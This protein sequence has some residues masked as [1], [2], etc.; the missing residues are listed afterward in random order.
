[1]ARIYR[2]FVLAHNSKFDR[3]NAQISLK[4]EFNKLNCVEQFKMMLLKYLPQ[5]NG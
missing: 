2:I 1:M 4:M 5:N 3:L